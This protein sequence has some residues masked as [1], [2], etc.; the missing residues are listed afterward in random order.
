MNAPAERGFPLGGRKIRIAENLA[1]RT[2][3]M[4]RPDLVYAFTTPGFRLFKSAHNWKKI[5]RVFDPARRFAPIG[6]DTPLTSIRNNS[7][8]AALRFRPLHRESAILLRQL[9]ASPS[10]EFL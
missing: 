7:D 6:M 1:L 8:P 5:G 2:G 4:D 10:G 9:L 3:P